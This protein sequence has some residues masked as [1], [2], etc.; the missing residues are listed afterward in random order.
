M[1]V[2]VCA[3]SM[4][5]RARVQYSCRGVMERER[6]REREMLVMTSHHR[7]GSPFGHPPRPSP[8]TL[9]Q[10]RVEMVGFEPWKTKEV[11][12]VCDVCV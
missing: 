8:L 7:R 11:M 3:M 5:I 10:N 12:C 1:C 4:M 2:C 6:E 9:S